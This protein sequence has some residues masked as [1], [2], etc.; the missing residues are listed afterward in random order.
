MATQL[1]PA[2][3]TDEELEQHAFNILSRE[4]GLAGY[5]RF[6]RLFGAGRGDYTADRHQWLAGLTID[7]VVRELENE[8]SPAS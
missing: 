4:L 1:I 7:D 3:M 5:A 6:L 2:N 8:K